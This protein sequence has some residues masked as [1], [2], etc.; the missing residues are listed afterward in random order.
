MSPTEKK[1][2][3]DRRTGKLTEE[4]IYCEPILRFLYDSKIGKPLGTLLAELPFF[5]K[6]LGW[7]YRR[8]WTKKR[9]LPFIAHHNIDATEFKQPIESYPSFNAFFVRTLKKE[10]RPLA[11]GPIIP[12][13][14]RYIF[15][16]DV[17]TC[18]SLD[19][20][21][22]KF[23]IKKIIGLDSVA[24]T[25]SQGSMV[26]ARLAP[27]DYHRF[28][29]PCDCTPGPARLI[30]GPFYS[31]HPLAFIQNIVLLTDNKRMITELKTD[32]Y[33]TVL[34]IEIGA[35]A[36]GSIHQ[37][38]QPGIPYKKGDE[39]GYFSFGGSCLILFFEKGRIQLANDI[40]THSAQSLE[41]LCR[42]GQPLT[43][44]IE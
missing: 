5:S 19:V 16:Q 39:K 20:K 34:F 8:S 33:G 37:T 9:I 21:N 12:A 42:M 31:I 3:I 22:K 36:V 1:Y 29:F 6:F 11:K 28:H 27:S 23:S 24:N 10:S 44:L 32:Q 17:A 13:D 41:T 18:N 14:G 40:L 30:N 4:R 25:Y 15:Y 26:I 43:E 35:T 2:Y 7:W 38:Y